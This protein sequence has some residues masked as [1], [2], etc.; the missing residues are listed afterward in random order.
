M[1]SP[2]HLAAAGDQDRPLSGTAVAEDAAPSA[3]RLHST[4]AADP[5]EPAWVRDPGL[6]AHGD[7]SATAKHVPCQRPRLSQTL[8]AEKEEQS[9]QKH[10]VHMPSRAALV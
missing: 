3:K 10:D 6:P 9:C 5:P 2:N 4:A 1:A 7:Q 8:D